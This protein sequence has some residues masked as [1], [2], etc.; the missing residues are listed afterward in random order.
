[1][2]EK[3][4]SPQ[5]TRLNH[6]HVQAAQSCLTDC[7]YACIQALLDEDLPDVV[8]VITRYAD[9]LVPVEAKKTPNYSQM[10]KQAIKDQIDGP[11]WEA[12]FQNNLEGTL[13]MTANTNVP[14]FFWHVAAET[15]LN[16][17]GLLHKLAW[18]IADHWH[19]R[20]WIDQKVRVNLSAKP[21]LL[22][23]SMAAVNVR[24]YSSNQKR[25]LQPV[26]SD[27][28]GLGDDLV[29]Q[30]KQP[31]LW[32]QWILVRAL[33]L[34]NMKRWSDRLLRGIQTLPL[35]NDVDNTD[36]PDWFIDQWAQL[37]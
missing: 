8:P 7:A 14:A 23:V 20:L 10:V 21:I 28:A 1:M 16:R 4:S 6:I 32:D 22:V 15:A 12:A 36:A 30:L 5:S 24:E 35:Y 9:A 27:I 31:T 33:R 26:V 13:G 3:Q 11:S 34:W 29:M 37:R 2:N 19:Q 25:Q 18:R 17:P